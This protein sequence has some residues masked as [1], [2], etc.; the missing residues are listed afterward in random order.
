MDSAWGGHQD[1]STE[2]TGEGNARG[3]ELRAQRLPELD[4]L[5]DTSQSVMA[6]SWVTGE[7]AREADLGFP[8]SP[9]ADVASSRGFSDRSSGV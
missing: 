3:K 6:Y 5:E 8:L 2:K 7:W 4:V 9:H 1:F